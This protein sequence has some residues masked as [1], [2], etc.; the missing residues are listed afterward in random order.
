MN[1]FITYLTF[2]CDAATFSRYAPFGTFF[3]TLMPDFRNRQKS[4]IFYGLSFQKK[5]P[6]CPPFFLTTRHLM[7]ALW[8][9]RI[10]GRLAV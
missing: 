9:G 1:V 2:F 7:E 10:D 3:N 5:Y 4:A 8:E 6:L